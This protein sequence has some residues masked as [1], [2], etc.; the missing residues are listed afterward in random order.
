MPRQH[1]RHH[2]A[3]LLPCRP[4]RAQLG[5]DDR[6][7]LIAFEVLQDLGDAEHADGK[8]HE[9]QPVGIV[10]DAEGEARGAGVDVGAD[11]AKQQPQHDHGQRLQDR[12]MR[13]RDGRHE[14][15]EHQS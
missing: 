3:K 12:T 2:P 5:P 10:G 14:A 6:P 11:E 4:E 1:R 9:V 13:K 8:G 15:E 7:V